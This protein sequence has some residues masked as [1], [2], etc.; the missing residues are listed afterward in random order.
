MNMNHRTMWTAGALAALGLMLA[1]LPGPSRTMRQQDEPA[2]AQ[3]QQR[4]EEAQAKLARSQEELNRRATLLA[5]EVAPRVLEKALAEVQ[6]LG[7]DD[8]IQIVTSFDEGGSW[9]GVETR[10]INAEKVKELKLSAERGV[11][12]TSV[13]PDS[14]AAK[15]GLKENDVITEIN[16]QRIEGAAQFRRLIREIPAGRTVQLNLIRDGH[17]QSINATLGKAEEMRK[18]RAKALPSRNFV[19]RTPEIPG[20]PAFAWDGEMLLGG[21]ARLGIDGEDLSGQLGSY[22]GAPDGE[23]ILVRD[24][25]SGSAAEKAGIKSGDV[26]TKFN[27]ERIRTVGDLRQKLAELREQKT[28]KLGLLR[29]HSE[30]SVDATIEAPEKPK[31]RKLAHSTNI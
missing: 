20:M 13:M 2:L 6:S 5:Q 28:V 12:L 17:P 7:G 11:L 18:V 1:A 10:D 31:T 15:A 24:V 9:L 14:P 21:R 30:I 4:L 29:N 23:G 25:H 8:D 22:F 19:F 3:L 26:L 16:G 27:G